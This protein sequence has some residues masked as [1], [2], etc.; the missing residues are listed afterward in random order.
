MKISSINVIPTS[1]PKAKRRKQT[2]GS[3]VSLGLG[4]NNNEMSKFLKKT[5][6]SI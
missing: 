1:I 4:Q 2:F 6:P 5:T 3:N